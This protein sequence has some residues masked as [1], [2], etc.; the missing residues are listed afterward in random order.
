MND[1]QTTQTAPVRSNPAMTVSVSRNYGEKD[2]AGHRKSIATPVGRAWK[3]T[4]GQGINV[5]LDLL[6]VMDHGARL[7]IFAGKKGLTF[8]GASERLAAFEVTE[9]TGRDGKTVKSWKRIGTAFLS[10]QKG[11]YDLRL[12]ALPHRKKLT[13]IGP[14]KRRERM[15]E[16]E[17]LAEALALKEDV[18]APRDCVG[19]LTP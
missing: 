14:R 13:L 11:A 10:S 5:T 3:H 9:F 1:A 18:S 7:V 2:D 4:N 16:S 12:S 19:S 6:P 8:E 17:V 15:Q